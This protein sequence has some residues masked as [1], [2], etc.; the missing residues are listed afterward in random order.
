MGVWESRIIEF[1]FSDFKSILKVHLKLRH[2][3]L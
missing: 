3:K 1:C 2:S